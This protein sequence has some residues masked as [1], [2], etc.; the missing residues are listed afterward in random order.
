MKRERS[1]AL[2]ADANVLIDYRDAGWEVLTVIGQNVGRVSVLPSV[3]AEVSGVTAADCTAIGIEVMRIETDRLLEAASIQ[4][5]VSFNDRLCFAT[6]RARG[7]TCVTN[8][9]ALRRLCQRRDV[10][11]RFGLGLMI[12]TVA[13]GALPRQIAEAVACKMHASNPRHITEEILIQFSRAIDE[14]CD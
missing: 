14:A 9:R 1:T 5:G 2:L 8:D 4:S 11:V 7:W 12:D 3:L 13:V 6:C 10:R